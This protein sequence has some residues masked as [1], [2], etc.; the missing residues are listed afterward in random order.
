MTPLICKCWLQD[1]PLWC[2]QLC[3]GIRPTNTARCTAIVGKNTSA[4]FVITEVKTFRLRVLAHVHITWL[5]HAVIAIVILFLDILPLSPFPLNEKANWH[6]YFQFASLGGFIL[7]FGFFAF[8]GSSQGSI[9]GE[10][11]GAAVAVAVT[12]TVMAASGGAFTTLILN[13]TKYFGDKK[14]S[15]LTTLNG[16]LTGMASTNYWIKILIVMT[17]YGCTISYGFF[18]PIG[19]CTQPNVTI[20]HHVAPLSNNYTVN[21]PHLQITISSN[22][23]KCGGNINVVLGLRIRILRSVCV[24]RLRFTHYKCA[25]LSRLVSL[26]PPLLDTI[27]KLSFTSS[28]V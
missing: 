17:S 22:E 27:V 14:W 25:R 24:F 8:N 21:L 18:K 16:C 15:F 28:R 4:P 6:F 23:K 19:L 20:S 5:C 11:D 2:N 7:V 10:G 3:W 1:L 13:R 26:A 12:N 9:S